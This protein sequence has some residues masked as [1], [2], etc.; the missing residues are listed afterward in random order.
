LTVDQVPTNLFWLAFAEGNQ[1]VLGEYA[2]NTFSRIKDP[3]LMK[4][5]ISTDAPKFEAERLV[6]LDGLDD[7]GCALAGSGGLLDGSYGR[8]VGVAPE[9]QAFAEVIDFPT[10]LDLEALMGDL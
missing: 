7:G 4:V 6:G 9:A 3:N 8:L 1:E 10:K 5:W 2:Q